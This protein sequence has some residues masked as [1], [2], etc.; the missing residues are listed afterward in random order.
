MWVYMVVPSKN[1][2]WLDPSKKAEHILDYVLEDTSEEAIAERVIQSSV[3]DELHK[4][5]VLITESSRKKTRVLF[6]TRDVTILEEGSTAQLHFKNLADVFDEIHIIIISEPWQTKKGVERLEKNIWAYTT[7]GKYWWTQ[8]FI[9]QSIARAQMQFT[10]G[11]RADVVV[12]L[13]PFESGLAGLMIAEKY[14]REFQVHVT[15]DFYALE[16][17]DKDKHNARRIKMAARVLKRAQS[18][19]VSTVLIKEQLEKKFRHL[20][21]VALLPRH[22]NINAII[23]ATETTNIKDVFPQYAFVVLFVGVLDHESTLF[24]AIDATRPILRSSRIGFVVVGDGPTKK[25][26]Q[27]RAEILGIQ[28]QIVFEKDESKL[29][30]YLKSADILICT[31]TTQ[32]SDEVVIK[33]AA[34]GLP[35]LAAKTELREDLFTDGESAF[36]CDKEDTVGFSQK[37]NKF[38]NANTLRTQFSDN[39]REIIKTR[40]HEDPEA[41]KRAYRDSIEGIFSVED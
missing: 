14:D 34:A 15:E 40:F 36:L 18:V 10:D 31:D 23:E 11:F 20:K 21:D 1:S 8:P 28:K 17:K 41:Y 4:E 33:A 26:S 5:S 24:R 6:I 39:A 13:D 2:A 19:R 7:S 12:A 37:L 16:F 35:I 22:Y 27:K 29:I 3:E 25:E 30:S 9:A 32:A 38:L